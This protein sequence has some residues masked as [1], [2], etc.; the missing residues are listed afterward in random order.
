M[1]KFRPA[2]THSH[3]QPVGPLMTVN[4]RFWQIVADG[5]LH[6]QGPLERPI[7]TKLAI[8]NSVLQSLPVIAGG[9]VWQGVMAINAA[10]CH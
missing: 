8:N 7:L 2:R 6:T 10:R 1:C 5:Q 9:L 3:Y 4:D